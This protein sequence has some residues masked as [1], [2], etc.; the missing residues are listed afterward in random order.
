MPVYNEGENIAKT[1]GEVEDKI[2][3]PHTILI[4][5]D[6]DEDNTIPVVQDMARQRPAMRVSLVRN[7]YGRGVLNA[8]RTGFDSTKDGVVLVVMADSSDDLPVVDSMFEKINQGYDIVCGSRYMRGGKQV[9]GP[10][11]KGLLSRVAGKSLHFVTGIPTH[12]ISNSFK[13][14]RKSVLTDIEIES[15][16]GFEIG[17]EIVVKA[18]YKG[19]RITEVPS[20]WLDRTAGKSRFKLM[21]WLPGYIRWYLYALTKRRKCSLGSE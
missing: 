11:I 6:F 4:V 14:Y 10:I 15:H 7:R 20:T 9:G 21:K 3:T 12:D 1:L 8:I 13:M 19:Y 5:Y 18:F 2:G 17:M 16:G